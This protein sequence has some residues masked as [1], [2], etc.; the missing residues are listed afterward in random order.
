M[1]RQYAPCGGVNTC[2]DDSGVGVEG[3]EGYGAD[4][5]RNRMERGREVGVGF[6][7]RFSNNPPIVLQ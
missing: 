6:L 3:S 7:S 5:R 1:V 4:L 2:K